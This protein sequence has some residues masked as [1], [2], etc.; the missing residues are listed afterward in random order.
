[1]KGGPNCNARGIVFYVNDNGQHGLIAAPEDLT[2]GIRW[3]AGGEPGI[4]TPTMAKGEGLI[5]GN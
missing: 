3:H 2:T 1:M 5:S 4:Y